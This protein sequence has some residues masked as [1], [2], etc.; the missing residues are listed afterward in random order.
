YLEGLYH[1]DPDHAGTF[2]AREG[3]YLYG[4]GDYEPGLIG[5]SPREALAMDPQQRL[6]LET[7]WEALERGGVDPL[8]LRGEPVGVFVGA[9]FMGYGIGSVESGEGLEGH[10]L[11]GTAS[12]VMSGRIS[13]SF[14][15]EGPAVTVDTACSSSLVA[16][17]LAA[18]ALRS[19]ECSMALVGGATVMPNADV[20]VE[21]SRQRGLAADGRCKSFGADADGTGWSEG[22]G[23]LLV[24]RLS[25]ARAA[26]RQVLAVVRGT[27]VNQDGASNGLTAPNGPSQ[28]RVIRAA[29]A[30]AG[31]NPQD[32]DAVEAH[33][34]GTTLGD[35]IEAQAL[36]AT[37]GQD[38]DGGD[39]LWLGSVKSNIGHTQA[40][41]GVAGIIKMLLAMRHETLPATL[42]ADDPSPHVEWS[43][44]EVE[45]L[46]ASRPWTPGDRPR[47]AGVSAFGVSGTNAHVIL[48]EAPAGEAPA[49][50]PEPTV[51][52]VLLAGH[53]ESALRA[54][55]ERLRHV[56]DQDLHAL[57][58]AAARRPALA[59][60]AVVLAGGTDALTAGLDA[61]ASGAGG[62]TGTARA[63]RVAFLFTGQG[64]QRASMGRGLYEAFPVFADAFD[65]VA[66]HVDADLDRPLA[67]VLADEELI[68]RTGY[69]QPALFAVEVALH[70]LLT[71]WGVRPDVLVGHSIG[72]IA[73]AHVAGV[74]SLPDAA[75]LVAAR[76]RLMQAL[77]AGGAML[78]VG[79]SEAD[80]LAAFPDVDVAVVNGP[81]AVVVAGLEAEID[82]VAEA[83]GERGWKTSRL[84]TS[85]AFQSRL[86]EPMLEDFRV[87]VKSLAFAEPSL[88]AVSTV[89]GRP[90][91]PG[92]W[93]DPEYWVDQVRK[94]VR[95]A[96]ALEALDGV[97]RFV[98]LGPDGV[99]SALVQQPDAVATPL[100]R[101]DR[102]E[103]TTALTA[104]AT[105]HV[106]GVP[107]DWS[108]FFT[109]VRPLELPAYAFQRQRYWLAAT[110]GA[111]DL[112]AAGLGAAEHPLLGAVVPLVDGDGT[113]LTGRLSLG[114]QPW[115]ADHVVAGAA[116]LPGTALLELALQAA[117]Q[118]GCDTV[119]EL[120]LHV[121]LVVPDRAAVRI[122]VTVDGPDE[123]GR[124]DVRIHSRDEHGDGWQ[125]HATGALA[126]AGAAAGRAVD[127]SAVWP[128]AGAVE[129]PLDGLYAGLRD[130]GLDYG[131]A[132]QAL[133]EVWRR[134]DD[135]FTEVVLGEEFRREAS[136]FGAHP[137]LIDAALH[138]LS[139]PGG[140]A[141]GGDADAVAR[142]PFSWSDVAVYA[143]GA[144]RLRV[145][146]SPAGGDA[147][148]LEAFTTTGQAV[149]AV[150]S[151]V[152]RPVPS[153]RPVAADLFAVEWDR[154]PAPSP[155]AASPR[156]AGWAVLGE[157]LPELPGVPARDGFGAPVVLVAAGGAGS[158]GQGAGG[159]AEVTRAEVRRVLAVVQSSLSTDSRVVVLTRNAVLPDGEGGDGG[160]GVDLAGAAVWGLLRSAQQE[161]PDRFVLVDV[162]ED[163]A[164]WL[165]LPAAVASGEPQVAV[166][167]GALFAPRLARTTAGDRAIDPTTGRATD[168][169]TASATDPVT[170]PAV[171][172]FGAGT[173]LITG[174]S[175]TLAGRV[176]RHLVASHGIRRLVLVSRSGGGEAV[177]WE[178]G[179][180]GVE[181]TLAAADVTDR[182]ALAAVIAGIP[183]EHPLTGVVHTAGVLDDGIV[184]QMTPDRLDRVLRPKVDG[185]LHLHELTRGL[186]LSAFVLFS[187]ASA[188]FGTPGQ[189]NYAAANGFLDAFA[190]HRRAL[191]LP[192]QALAWGP[193]AEGGMAG[194]LDEADRQRMARAGVL[195][196]D[197]ASGLAA[198]DAA[199]TAAAAPVVP[200]RLD[201]AA[202][203]A[204][205]EV[206]ALL[207]GLVRRP[208]VRAVAPTVV[209]VAQRLAGLSDEARRELLLDLVHGHMATV[210]GYP[211]DHPTE[212]ARGFLDQGFDSLTAVELRNG[213]TAVTGLRLPA[214]VIFDYPTPGDLAEHLFEQLA[215][216][217]PVA[218]PL[219]AL[220]ELDRFEASLAADG[221]DPAVR[222]QIADRLR[223][224]LAGWQPTEADEVVDLLEEASDE[225]MFAFIDN[226]LGL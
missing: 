92:E 142:L 150:G 96:D 125:H 2:D 201:L 29:L 141:E 159:V 69:A 175:G 180:E 217:E 161:N 33:G 20:F 210:L 60:R 83:A 111:G 1:P 200:I 98:E 212:P 7:S 130:M 197:V 108:P 191:G 199:V 168:P 91:R 35:P 177:A 181:V 5:I 158:G 196:F 97:T 152:M 143:V 163:A 26:G 34:T 45:L 94:P 44:G 138:A 109:G 68:H 100:L 15:L 167:G 47:R 134:G 146:I 160:D 185:T 57:A 36:L 54:Q 102:D 226:D 76:G 79:A 129:V 136:R 127:T 225:E 55:A 224:L 38:R 139:L 170:D 128:P 49:D 30:Q 93:S 133:R 205:G 149:L 213:L 81:G 53:T 11:T 220:A 95:F 222:D 13:Y 198:F 103:V 171:G 14:G 122:Q 147:V 186:E 131:P 154:V 137:A 12:S 169:T 214:T 115:L 85:H 18:Q 21:F 66:L 110:R 80:V 140:D 32:V 132:F 216:V 28:Q 157:P 70:A 148:R 166:R 3:G 144:D 106:N 6:L 42:H 202:V 190:Q 207:S 82:A 203:R 183:A 78:A 116:L 8:G 48:E 86:R 119:E 71:H 41:A 27:A 187:S 155:S 176:A 126:P 124:R 112:G 204:A 65:Q 50:G 22:V 165:A 87:I 135:L 114:D 23:M 39:P 62:L 189:A 105:L 192:G 219:P 99:L 84:R 121:P 24:E 61:V 162:D 16:L 17:H 75:T 188:V 123:R 19:G 206:P 215:P 72:E 172:S 64:A 77:P 223:R 113:V 52:P 173:V 74:L 194:D 40:A 182:A 151:L 153:T 63:G 67:E 209:P 46:T 145:R 9:S 89:T 31:L 88:P 174:G 10:L 118:V 179:A 51:V 184:E 156:A 164:S 25:S 37:Y 58:A 73:A 104:L 101:R 59:H 193:W 56:A 195:P 90:V 4:A 117:R 221:L 178:L 107:V 43:G 211:A 208:A 120:T 218:P